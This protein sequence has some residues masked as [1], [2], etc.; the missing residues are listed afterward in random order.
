MNEMIEIQCP[1]C[2]GTVKRK[3]NDYFAVCPYCNSE[4]GFNELKEEAAVTGM[5]SRLETLDRHFKNEQEFKTARRTWIK[6]TRIMLASATIL[7]LF[8]FTMAGLGEEDSA[9]LGFGVIL[10]IFSLMIF[11][12]GPI[13]LAGSY[14]EFN[15]Q[16]GTA[17]NKGS[18]KLL[19][20][21][22]LMGISVLLIFFAA[23]AAALI[24]YFADPAAMK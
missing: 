16:T 5:R 14:T 12:V 24:C 21:L 3:Q 20:W 19:M 4:I 1:N 8:G 10:L 11:L 9:M 18:G 17:E 23:L 22:R 6:T 7:F 15:D 13:L 2:G